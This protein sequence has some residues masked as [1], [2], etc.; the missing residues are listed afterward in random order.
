MAE[1]VRVGA[2]LD[3]ALAAP[4]A[5]GAWDRLWHFHREPKFIALWL[6]LFGWTLR[7]MTPAR[8]RLL[9]ALAALYFAVARPWEEHRQAGE[10]LKFAPR[11]IEGAIVNSSCVAAVLAVHAVRTG[12]AT[13]RPVDAPWPDRPTR[14]AA[15]K[16]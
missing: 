3:D 6:K 9:L 14:F 16:A 10:L 13:T 5:A 7:V 8:R 11:P 15:R 1:A 4:V 2:A 12:A